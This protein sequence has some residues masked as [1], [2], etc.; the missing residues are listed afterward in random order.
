MWSRRQAFIDRITP[1][2]PHA[3]KLHVYTRSGRAAAA[4]VRANAPHLYVH[5]KMAVI[6]DELMLIGSANC[7]NRGWETDSELVVATFED[8]GGT[9]PVAGRLRMA[10]WAHH[11]GVHPA[12]GRRPGALARALGYS[13]HAARLPVR[14]RRRRRFLAARSS[15]HFVDPSDRQPGDPCRTLLPHP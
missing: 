7:N 13:E 8:D 15:G 4:C 10:L 1:G 5:A 2:N 14:P 11:L 12:D 3:G 6:D 9:T